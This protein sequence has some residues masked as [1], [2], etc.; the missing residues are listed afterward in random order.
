MIQII[1]ARDFDKLA[2]HKQV[3]A[4]IAD[5]E[6]GEEFEFLIKYFFMDGDREVYK[7]TKFKI[8]GDPIIEEI[9]V[10][11]TKEK[12]SLAGKEDKSYK[13]FSDEFSEEVYDRIVSY[14]DRE[15]ILA[16]SRE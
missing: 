12:F 4:E 8:K 10:M 7:T 3:F 1:Q 5:I 11:H 15:I 2:G 9:A 14:L 16:E 6:T 13:I